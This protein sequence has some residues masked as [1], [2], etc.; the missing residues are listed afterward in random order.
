MSRFFRNEF[1]N[2]TKIVFV[3]YRESVKSAYGGSQENMNGS[4]ENSDKYVSLTEGMRLAGV[5]RGMF[6]YY[7][8]NGEIRPGPGKAHFLRTDCL[9]VHDR[10]L[11]KRQHRQAAQ[12][13]PLLYDWITPGDILATLALDRDLYDGDAI[14]YEI[15]FNE[16]AVYQ[17]RQRKNPR[18]AL[19]AFTPDRKTC[20]GYLSLIPLPESVILDIM[21]GRRDE[22]SIKLEEVEA[23][24][25]P[26][27]YALFCN[28]AAVAHGQHFLLHKILRRIVDF[29][30]EEQYPERWIQ[31]IYAQA[32]SDDGRM[33]IAHFFFAPISGYPAE[34]YYLDLARPNP[35][36][37]IQRYMARLEEKATLPDDLTRRY[38]PPLPESLARPAA[39]SPRAA[40]PVALEVLRKAYHHTSATPPLPPDL[41][42]CT[43]FAKAH[44]IAKSTAQK[45]LDTGRLECASG[46]PWLDGRFVIKQAFDAAGRRAFIA[47]YE[48]LPSFHHCPDCPHE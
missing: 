22:L 26:G 45:A 35:S 2:L 4:Q 20:L 30:V 11:E 42:A 38:V 17:A 28:S 31:R 43:S 9:R 12:R 10:R 13:D 33:M 27:G 37:L 15:D 14:D 25:R 18:I 19:G 3:L 44:G 40:Q 48:N 46:G 34:A 39:S 29:W 41:V 23:Y 36:Q 47:A 1:V 32:V 5:K 21:T 16:P 6:Y 7:V 24:D 8:N